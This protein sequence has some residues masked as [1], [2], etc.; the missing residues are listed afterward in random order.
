M[1]DGLLLAVLPL[2][3]ILLLALIESPGEEMTSPGS[4]LEE[5]SVP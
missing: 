2:G 5:L 4:C 1:T 3:W